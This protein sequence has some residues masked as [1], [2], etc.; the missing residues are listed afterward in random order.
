MFRKSRLSIGWTARGPFG[1]ARDLPTA[2]F[3][4]LVHLLSIEGV[5]PRQAGILPSIDRALTCFRP[6]RCEVALKA[7]DD[8]IHV[9]E[10]GFGEK[11]GR[12]RTAIAG[13]A[14]QND[15]AIGIEPLRTQSATHLGD[16]IRIA[17]EF[18]RRLCCVPARKI[19][20]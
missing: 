6:L 2:S 20:L 17:F 19:R 7:I 8:R 1:L 9:L 12:G 13:T 3:V 5:R 15:G 11:I 14:N 4:E 18:E 10:T 16:E